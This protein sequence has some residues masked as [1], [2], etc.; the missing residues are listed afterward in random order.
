[1]KQRKLTRIAA[2]MLAMLLIVIPLSIRAQARPADKGLPL[3]EGEWR[4]RL[5]EILT[6]KEPQEKRVEK[7]SLG[8]MP[9]GVRLLEEGV[10][11]VGLTGDNS[12]AAVAGL[13]PKDRI[14]SIDGKEMHSVKDVLDAIDA[15]GG[16]ELTVEYLRGEEKGAV[17]VRPALGGDHKYRVG[18]WVRDG[19][20][21]IGTIT[22]VDA[23]TGEFGGLGHGICDPESGEV[24]PFERG[25]VMQTKISGVIKGKEGD[26]GELKG[27]LTQEKIGI[28]LKNCE[29]GVFGVL[30]PIPP[31]LGEA[32]I[33]IGTAKEVHSGEAFLR[34]TLEDGAPTDY[35]IELSDIKSADTATRCFAVHVT[36]ERLL[37]KTGGIVQGMSGSPIIQDGKLIGAVTHV[38]IGDPTRGYGIFI[39]NMLAEMRGIPG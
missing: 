8:G 21:G 38:L 33:E 11:I 32:T 18:V 37:A 19:A 10:L 39:E 30:S 3:M 34:C 13:S 29:K 16:K 7:L 22:Y 24:L 15:S 27:Y 28:L 36:D 14:L 23:V 26:P 5:G 17:T 4:S 6:G 2:F 35:R 25:A 12:P 31:S 20:A 1:M 9:F